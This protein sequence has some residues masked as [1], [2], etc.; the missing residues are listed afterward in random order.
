MTCFLLRGYEGMQEASRISLEADVSS[1]VLSLLESI[2]FNGYS[3]HNGRRRASWMTLA[4]ADI[5]YSKPLKNTLSLMIVTLKSTGA[6]LS[7][8]PLAV[9]PESCST[10][11]R[12]AIPDV[13]P[14]SV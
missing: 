4:F 6:E 7:T 13:A 12:V 8:P 2:S 14:V 5:A 9:P 10:A 11:R 1:A 3:G